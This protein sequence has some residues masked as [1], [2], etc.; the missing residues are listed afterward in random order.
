MYVK[1]KDTLSDSR[2]G[3]VELSLTSRGTAR[4]QQKK[5]RTGQGKFLPGIHECLNTTG[6][7]K[8]NLHDCHDN[9]R[10]GMR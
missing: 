9:Y 3:V 10:Y 2:F 6:M 5:Q 8:S 4:T 7:H 1:N